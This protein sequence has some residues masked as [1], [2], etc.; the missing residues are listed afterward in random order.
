LTAAIF[1]LI[2]V[3][4]GAIVTGAVDLFMEWRR[5]KAG[6]FL[7]KRLVGE[8]LQTIWIHLDGLLAS[9]A[10]PRTDSAE[11]RSRFMPTNAWE[12]HKGTLALKGVLN[13]DEWV[14]LSS[15]LHAVASLQLM[16]VE[17]PP[18]APLPAGSA[19]K[20]T[21]Q[22]EMVAQLY[23]SLTGRELDMERSG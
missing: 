16:I 2:G 20:I 6:V 15:V 7:S 4:V 10:T 9:G 19:E 8:E 17:L 5:K 23:E 3:V 21:E 11:R 18:G 13:D 14:W 12:A 1:G 22:I